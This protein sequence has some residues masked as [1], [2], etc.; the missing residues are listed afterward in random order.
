MRTKFFFANDSMRF[1]RGFQERLVRV[2]V[3]D[4]ACGSGNFLY[5]SLALMKALEK[6]VVAFATAH[7]LDD[8]VP[9]VHPAPAIR[10]RD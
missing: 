9:R 7:G 3:L 2:K 6:E 10:N 5:V 8:F 1:S 4:P